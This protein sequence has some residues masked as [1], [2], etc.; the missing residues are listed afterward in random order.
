MRLQIMLRVLNSLK[1]SAEALARCDK[2][3]SINPRLISAHISRGNALFDLGRSEQALAS[4]D[5]ALAISPELASAWIN[6]AR[7]LLDMGRFRDAVAAFDRG[8]KAGPDLEF[9]EAER[10]YAKMNFCDWSNL[11]AECRHLM[12]GICNGSAIANPYTTFVISSSLDDQVRCA[13]SFVRHKFP[14]YPSPLWKGERYGHERIRLA[15]V[16]SDFR[17]HPV[18]F[19][20]AE[21][22]EIHDRSRFE[23][24]AI[25]YGPDDP[26]EMRQRLK[27]SFDRFV[28]VHARSDQDIAESIRSLEIDIAVDLQGFTHSGRPGIFARRPAPVQVSYL[29]FPGTMGAPF[30]D[31]ILADR[32]VIPEEQAGSY[33]ES[34]AYLPETFQVNDSTRQITDVAPSRV[35]AGLPELGFVFCCFNAA[36]KIEPSVFDVWMRLLK[37]VEGSVLWLAQT[38]DDMVANLRREAEA[39]GVPGSRLVFAQRLP[40]LEDHLARHRLADLFLD[41][42]HYNAHTTASDALW[43]GLPVLTCAGAAYASRVAGSLLHAVGLP[44]L[45]TYSIGEY[46]A[47]AMKLATQ[48]LFLQ[49]IRRKLVENLGRCPLFDTGRFRRHIEAAYTTM[50]DIYRAGESPRS[51]TV[52]TID[53]GER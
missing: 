31:Y 30:I 13:K 42:F 14:S 21:L 46:E 5:R 19:L 33:S 16:S 3:L 24:I 15:Y 10:L 50:A 37:N 49:T 36:Y 26:S 29:G 45:V 47:L 11:E 32:F 17:R 40:K 1:R 51:F 28:D 27:R 6:R 4:Y 41:T 44:E 25:S 18:A 23:I 48:P 12:A 43:A 7:T 52:E 53:T 2:A 35:T 8:L 22:F 9:A 39:R 20:M 38:N 34:V